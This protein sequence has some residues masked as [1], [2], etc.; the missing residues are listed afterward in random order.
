MDL[1]KLAALNDYW[2]TH[3]PIHLLVAAFVG[4]KPAPNTPESSSD[5]A[6]ESIMT[7]FPQ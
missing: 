6:A 3:P 1:P 7:L 4:F 5:D 2:K